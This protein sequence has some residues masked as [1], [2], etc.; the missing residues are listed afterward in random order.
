MKTL[1]IPLTL[2]G[3][4]AAHAD[5]TIAPA[6]PYAYAANF[7]WIHLG[8]GSPTNGHSY[9]NT[10]AND[11]GVN[12]DSQGRLTGYA[13][14]ANVGWITFEQTRGL[15]KMN[16]LTGKFTGHA[17]GANIGWISLDTTTSDL[18]TATMS[19]PD[20]DSD[21]IG[22]AWERANFGRLTTA[23]ALTDH[24]G[25][26]DQAD[27]LAGTDPGDAA[28]RLRITE[29]SYSSGIFNTAKLTFTS[30]PNRLY[31]IESSPTLQAPWTV[32]SLGTFSPDAGSTTSK[33]IL[34]SG[35][36]KRFF[37]VR[38]HKPLQP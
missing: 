36:P 26:G 23:N 32:S 9:A 37:R 12:M 6:N 3:S 24:D 20:T 14:A 16:F 11:Y 27:Y 31:A 2:L 22:D 30:V 7:G 35:G 5:T 25:D 4:I 28:S 34:H 17:W 8:D 13:Y 21:G 10:S 18:V 1:L 38:A 29:H 15:P 33:T 19:C